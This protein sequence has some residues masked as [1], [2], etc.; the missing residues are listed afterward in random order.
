MPLYEKH[1]TV[2]VSSS[3][4]SSRRNSQELLFNLFQMLPFRRTS[5]P[6]T[7]LR[8]MR[9]QAERNNGRPSTLAPRRS[10]TVVLL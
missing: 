2:A 7:L 9:R 5:L 3:S 4:S 10:A 6:A 8:I 1:R